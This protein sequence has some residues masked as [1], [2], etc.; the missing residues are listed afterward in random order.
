MRD[1]GH[2]TE[3]FLQLHRDAIPGRWPRSTTNKAPHKPILLMMVS[4]H[5]IVDPDRS[6]L[7]VLDELLERRFQDY[8]SSVFGAR[9]ESTVALPFFHLKTD[10]FWHLVTIG[11][12]REDGIPKS[13]RKSLSALKEMVSAATLDTELHQLLANPKLAAHFRS[14]LVTTYFTPELHARFFA[15]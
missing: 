11:A 15:E 6:N 14:V 13:S 3:K 8:W 2:Y 7:V 4:D 9:G 10:G 1:A 5:Y 12:V